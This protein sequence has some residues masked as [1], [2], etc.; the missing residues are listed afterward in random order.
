MSEVTPIRPGV[1]LE[2]DRSEQAA[3]SCNEAVR[4]P[5]IDE[6]RDY[7]DVLVLNAVKAAIQLIDAE[8]SHLAADVLRLARDRL[9]AS[10]P[11]TEVK[12]TLERVT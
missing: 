11:T 12:F 10:W 3:R 9:E 5:Y 2:P 7:Q 1:T 8:E 6:D 4:V